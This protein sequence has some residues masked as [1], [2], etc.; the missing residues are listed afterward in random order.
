M[1]FAATSQGTIIIIGLYYIELHWRVW[2]TLYKLM[3]LG[4]TAGADAHQTEAPVN[5]RFI[6]LYR[7][8]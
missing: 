4:V 1:K 5:A 2:H 6:E 7:A 8:E 3:D